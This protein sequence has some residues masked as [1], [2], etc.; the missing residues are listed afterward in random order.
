M[1]VIW[2]DTVVTSSVAWIGEPPYGERYCID[3]LRFF[4]DNISGYALTRRTDSGYCYMGV[5]KT[6][7]EAKAEAERREK[8]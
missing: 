8:L 1:K 7:E 6:V 3:A 4:D 2:Q 5:F